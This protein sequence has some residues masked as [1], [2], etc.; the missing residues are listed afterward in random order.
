MDTKK[1]FG[2][3]ILNINEVGEGTYN[4]Y[5][6]INNELAKERAKECLKC[7]NMKDDFLKTFSKMDKERIP[8]IY[9][10][11]CELC[12]CILSKK[13]RLKTIKIEEQCLLKF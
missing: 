11:Y 7:P 12:G 4:Y 6:G 5:M 8:K 1:R 13:L 9:G 10:K 3:A 2:K